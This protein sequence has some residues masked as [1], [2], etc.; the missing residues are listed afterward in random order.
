MAQPSRYRMP[1]GMRP[2]TLA[3]R[4]D[5]YRNEFDM[6]AVGRWLGGR[7]STLFAVKLGKLTGIQRPGF[8]HDPYDTILLT[9]T[10]QKDLRESLLYHLPES[11]YYDRTVYRDLG[12]EDL[13]APDNVTGQELAF[14]LD[15]ENVACPNCGALKERMERGEMYTFCLWCFG[16]VR[17]MAV[18]LWDYLRPGFH[19][20][21]LVYSGRGI[22]IHVGDERATRMGQEERRELSAV[23]LA[24]GIDHDVWVATGSSRLIRL[25]FSL[26][27][28]VSRVVVPIPRAHLEV[29]DPVREA[30]PSF[31]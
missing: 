30:R 22:H 9:Q 1:D 27:G 3:D 21:R 20:L 23:I 15:P 19:D 14:D 26:H 6:T 7:R 16:R 17:E 4:E 31:L 25:P 2:A 28:L 11:V 24:E 5:F 12:A 29:F 8:N 18:R 13:G 10:T